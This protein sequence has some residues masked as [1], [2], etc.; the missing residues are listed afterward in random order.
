M[1]HKSEKVNGKMIGSYFG[2]TDQGDNKVMKALLLGI[3]LAA[4][5][6][7]SIISVHAE[8]TATNTHFRIERIFSANFEPSSMAFVGQDDILILDRDF[9]KVYRITDGFK[10]PPILDVNVGT[11]GYRGLLGMAVTV[12]EKEAIR[13]YLYFTETPKND[14]DDASKN[15]VDPLGNMLYRYD[16]VDNKL[17]NPKLLLSLPA[18]PG[19]RHAGGVLAIGPDNN[20]YFTIGDLDGTF[21]STQ[22]E[23]MAQNYQEG[24]VPDGRS[25]IL[26]TTQNGEPTGKHILGSSFP[27]NLYYAYGIR[28]SFGIDWDPETGYLW[29][30]E[31]GPN[32]GDELNLVQSGFNSGWASVQGYW[33][34]DTE[35][36]G[37]LNLSPNDLVSFGGR[38]KYSTPEFTWINPASPSA[39]KFLDTNKYG[40]EYK[41]D[42]LVGDANNGNIYDFNLDEQRENFELSGALSDKI[43]NNTG[44]INDLVF[45]NG[46]G[47]VTDMEIGPDGLLYVLSTDNDLTSVY[48][49]SPN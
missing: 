14:G 34:P 37:S 41:N 44:E 9:G 18:L 45:A 20:I 36:M 22:Y 49:I 24:T 30:S 11:D 25:G 2:V 26:V 8:P 48:R 28:N 43:A 12:N 38:G 32:F 27:L 7:I 35:E 6:L 29:D 31:N 3:V 39:I 23:T 13:V 46:F 5:Q 21:R 10:S 15:P 19:P 17:I 40:P 42:L 33:K 47:R 16:L 4:A 1:M